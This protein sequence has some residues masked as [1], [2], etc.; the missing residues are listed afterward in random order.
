MVFAAETRGRTALLMNQNNKFLV[1][2][3][4]NLTSDK[5]F[6]FG[7]DAVS[8]ATFSLET[9][10][11]SFNAQVHIG[12]AS[13][14]KWRRLYAPSKIAAVING[15]NVLTPQRPLV[16]PCVRFSLTRLSRSFFRQLAA[17]MLRGTFLS[18]HS[19]PPCY[20]RQLQCFASNKACD[21]CSTSSQDGPCTPWFVCDISSSA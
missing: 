5:R 12:A 1:L 16:K 15:I 14:A 17:E 11:S 18:G 21:S 8:S 20:I 6:V 2:Q 7:V 13:C 4:R 10:N 3:I 9:N 19:S